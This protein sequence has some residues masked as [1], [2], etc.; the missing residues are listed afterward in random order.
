VK[1]NLSEFRI[2]LL[3]DLPNPRTPLSVL[4]IIALVCLLSGFLYHA[5][6]TRTTRENSRPT[7]FN[8][9]NRKFCAENHPT[10]SGGA[11]EPKLSVTSL[12][13]K[14]IRI[15]RQQTVRRDCPNLLA[16]ADQN[17]S[18][19]FEDFVGI[20]FPHNGRQS[21]PKMPVPLVSFFTYIKLEMT[22][23][24]A[25]FHFVNHFENLT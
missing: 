21:E 4:P 8:L 13:I 12:T 17:R 20:R 15:W 25:F 14:Q 6:S 1:E 11:R 10:S 16:V 19:Q 3:A 18:I 24:V 9:P 5:I 22:L 2:S 7:K 23:G